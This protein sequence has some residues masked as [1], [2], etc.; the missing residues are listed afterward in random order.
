MWFN[1]RIDHAGGAG[2]VSV[3]Q[4][5]RLSRLLLKQNQPW[6]VAFGGRGV[7]VEP[8]GRLPV[9]NLAG[10][11]RVTLMSPGVGRAQGPSSKWPEAVAGT[12]LAGPDSPPL[13]PASPRSGPAH[14]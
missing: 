11:M 8:T 6:N 3:G 2:P 9:L 7:A 13:P 4:G 14:R 10:N 1:D 12:A 5:N